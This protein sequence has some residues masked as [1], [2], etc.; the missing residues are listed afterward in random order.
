MKTVLKAGSAYYFRAA[1]YDV[2]KQTK[3]NV[4]SEVSATP[5][6]KEVS[7]AFQSCRGRQRYIGGSLRFSFNREQQN[8]VVL[9]G[10]GAIPNGSTPAR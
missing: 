1:F 7:L 9:Y 10:W 8:S 3:L 2:F 4:S 6:T 5:L